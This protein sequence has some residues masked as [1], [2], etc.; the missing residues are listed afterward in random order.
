[1]GRLTLNMLLSFAQFEREI[2]GERVRDKKLA[3]T[4]N[5]MWVN[6]RPPHG[7]QV[8][9]CVLSPD[10][11]LKEEA[12]LIFEKYLELQSVL[13]LQAWLTESGYT[14]RSG[15]S[16]QKGPLYNMLANRV[17]LGKLPYKD[18]EFEGNYEPII[19]KKLFDEVQ[20]LLKGN[21]RSH[22]LK[23]RA[24]D[25]SLLAGLLYGMDNQ[26]YYPSHST[27]RTATPRDGGSIA[28]A[29]GCAERYKRYRYYLSKEVSKHQK[30]RL[31]PLAQIPEARM[32]RCQMVHGCTC[33]AAQEI[34]EYVQAITPAIIR[35]EK[36]L[37]AFP[38]QDQPQ[39]QEKLK[40]EPLKGR[41]VLLKTYRKIIISPESIELHINRA[42]I[43]N[44][45]HELAYNTEGTF[46]G[47]KTDIITKAI[48]LKKVNHGASV[49]RG[50]AISLGAN[51]QMK[52]TIRKSF[53]YNRQ[54]LTDEC[55]S[56]KELCEAQSLD[57]RHTRRVLNLRF[58]A[59][60]IL[61]KILRD[62]VPAHWTMGALFEAAA[63][64]HP[65]GAT[66]LCHAS[67]A[68]AFH[69]ATP[70]QDKL[71]ARRRLLPLAL[72]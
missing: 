55:H 16:W 49:I 30:T 59:G 38:L 62:R 60:D 54:L 37:E 66:P 46:A 42:G 21:N 31:N 47:E 64:A 20:E 5:G 52:E 71:P 34:E 17:Y 58:L 51:P 19:P 32:P 70:L 35:D 22:R 6:G 11:K 72:V 40:K 3:M 48:R 39:I 41:E 44:F 14:T 25:S 65:Q 29:Q 56:L 2:A 33:L 1:M 7:Y 50:E 18:E 53:V 43:F 23:S 67:G 9:K 45:I 10:P 15:K 69:C 28:G 63:I 68:I 61:E 4:K 24:K 27:K 26:K 57:L 12:L 36:Y 8:E 13:K